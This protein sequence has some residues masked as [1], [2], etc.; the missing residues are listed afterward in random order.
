MPLMSPVMP[1]EKSG[2]EESLEFDGQ[3]E[4]VAQSGVSNGDV[5]LLLYA[6]YSLE[7]QQGSV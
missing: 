2:S 5:H 4:E 1:V 7:K 6:K 3:S